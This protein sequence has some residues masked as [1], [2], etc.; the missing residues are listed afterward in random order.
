MLK[1]YMFFIMVLTGISIVLG[2]SY[3]NFIVASE[4]HK[5]AEMYIGTLKYSMSIDGT[6]TN[7]LSVPSGETIVDVTITNENPIDTYYKLIYQNNSNVTIKY[8]ESTKDTNDNVTNYSSP[9]SKITSKNTNTIKLKI[10]NSST[11]SQKVT[12]KIVGGFATNTLDD[13]T[14]LTGYTII[15]K[16]TSTNTYFCTTTDTLTQGLKYVNGQYTYAYKQRGGYSTSGLGWNNI[17]NNG[18][19]VQLTN[20]TSTDSVTSKV[21]T[22][23]NNKPV[24]SMSY[25]FSD[26][27]PT[28]LDVSNF[29]TS[30]VAVMFSMFYNSQATTLDLSN[31]NTSNVRDMGG[32]FSNSKATILDVSNFDTSKV[33]NMSSMFSNSKATTLDVSNFDTSNVTDM[34]YM[35]SGS[36]ATTLDL[37]NFNTSKVTSMSSM[38]SNSQATTLDVSNFDTSNV[39][40]MWGMFYNSQATTIDVSNFDTSKV[41]DMGSMFSRSQATTIDVSNFNTSKVTNM[42]VMFDG[43]QATTLDV[44][45]FDTS[46]VT[47]MDGMFFGNQATTLDVSN[48]D[49]SNVTN[50]Y[51]MFSDSK[52]TTLDVSNFDTSNV[53]DMSWMFSRSQATT[54]DLS[55]FD[56]SK[57]TNMSYMF[58]KAT[59]LKTIYGSSKFVTT[60]V[61]DSTDMFSD[62][63]ALV[64]GAGTKYNSS[65][66]DK[67]YARIDGGTS[68]PGYF[69][70]ISEPNSFSTDSWMTIAKAVKS[71]NISKYN[72]GDTKSVTLT[73]YGTH[74][75]RIANTS[76]PSECSTSGFSQSACG[77]VV[78]FA[79][80]ITT[81]NMNG[82]STNKGG[83]PASSMYTFVNTDIYNALPSDLRNVIINTTV[84]SSH[85]SGDTSNF[86]S[87]DKLY[88]LAPKEIYTD[89]SDSY[90]TA[91]DLTR[92]L[93]YYKNVGVTNNNYSGAIKKKGTDN[94]F[95]WLRA[96]YYTRDYSTFYNIH[97][98]GAW[99]SSILASNS[100]GG[101]SPAFRLG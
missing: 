10:T 69:T 26:S 14:V 28:I 29:D 21:C 53:T 57:V 20:K 33:T 34:G 79:D 12:F 92:I 94:Y 48:F 38:F 44:S 2:M 3:S 13:V 51:G 1:K 6:N 9:N 71:G 35:F 24:V 77:F 95:W 81:H 93:D 8:Y 30:K 56:T 65:Y 31:F 59:N 80:I 91:K 54:I 90:D 78:E 72:V 99:N 58:Y 40:N 73:T 22:Y 76:T 87:T 85:G 101:V 62:C 46:N 42:S 98:V 60:A 7:T 17:S 37:S 82:S 4:N 89:F 15:G 27:K 45:N 16:D 25:M 97:H 83:W 66:V 23:I 63:T 47:Y 68:N 50:M 75:L 64:G 88:L 43:S 84:V 36:Q 55:S 70:S 18:W 39:T 86:T 49:T 96:A 19:G 52:A 74:T 11:S 100:N 32:M 67:T 5:V 41:T 61:T